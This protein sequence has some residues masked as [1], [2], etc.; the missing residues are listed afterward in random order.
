MNTNLGQEKVSR[1]LWELSIP[2]ILGMLSSA[3]FNIADRYF[4]G[5][6]SPLALSGVGITMPIQMFQMALIL[7]IG[8]GSSTLISIRLGE[9]KK[10][11][12]EDILFL[13]FKYIVISMLVF[14]LGFI[15]FC[16]QV[17]GWIS[18]SDA[19]HQYARPYILIIIVGSV[20]GIPGYCLNNSLRSIGKANITMKAILWSSILNIILDPIFIFALD[21]GI[22]GAAIATV[23][24]QMALTIYITHYFIKNKELIINLKYKKVEN[25]LAIL[26]RIFSNGSPSFFTQIFASGVNVYINSNAVFYGSDLD[27]AAMTIISTCFSFYHMFVIGISQ[28]NQPIIG[29]NWGSKQY[30]RVRTSLKLSLFYSSLISVA[31]WFLIQTYPDL[32]VGFFTDDPDLIAI[33]VRGM[34]LYLMM[35]FLIGAQTI[36]TQYFQGVEK[37]KLSTFL[38]VLRYGVILVPSI[39]I[40]APRVGVIGIYASNAISDGIAS[41]IAIFFIIKE[42]K[43]LSQL[44]K[45]NS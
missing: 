1:L 39:A 4:V 45:A 9:G 16:D 40:L 3:I 5:K 14:A 23:I 44:E 17:L 29:Y 30:D 33:S 31:L 8:I 37:P 38:M 25:E 26:K 28:G 10:E 27:V 36:A 20:V 22:A 6:I 35:I 12:A 21:M 24:S 34:K 19:V 13:S 42:M 2:A 11:E 43:N 41:V 18:V 32:L 15:V 7:L